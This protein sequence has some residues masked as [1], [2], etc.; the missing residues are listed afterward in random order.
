MHFCFFDI[1]GTLLNTGGAGQAAMEDALASEF[2]ITVPTE[3]VSTAGRTDRAITVELMQYHGLE[4]RDETW[5]RFLRAYLNCLPICLEKYDGQ[6]LPGVPSLLDALSDRND[7]VIGLLTGNF[8]VGARLKLEY[9]DLQHHFEFGSFGDRHL[10]RN[11]VAREALDEAHKRYK[12]MVASDRL[13]VVGDTPAD[14][15]CGRAIDAQVVA[16]STGMYSIDQL[17]AAEPDHLFADFSHPEPL[18]RLFG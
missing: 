17:E 16:V 10:D 8:E 7:V 15:R 6:I 9:Y 3:G 13:W 18:L 11:D 14:V 5:K 4:D 2:G 1:D 12:G